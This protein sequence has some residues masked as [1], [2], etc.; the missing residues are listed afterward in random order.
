MDRVITIQYKLPQEQ[1]TLDEETSL[2]Q[3]EEEA[4][5]KCSEAESLVSAKA[6][7]CLHNVMGQVCIYRYRLV[8]IAPY[9]VSADVKK[10]GSQKFE[11]NWAWKRLGFSWVFF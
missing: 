9:F 7:A 1:L 5:S 4:L 2:S 6:F 3:P 10:P 8:F 11:K